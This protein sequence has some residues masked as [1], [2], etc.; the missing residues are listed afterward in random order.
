MPQ[1]FTQTLIPLTFMLLSLSC[2]KHED[3]L[4]WAKQDKSVLI[5]DNPELNVISVADD[6][7]FTLVHIK[8]SHFSQIYAEKLLEELQKSTNLQQ[9]RVKQIDYHQLITNINSQQ[10]SIIDFVLKNKDLI[11][12]IYVEGLAYPG[13]YEVTSYDEKITLAKNLCQEIFTLKQ[14]KLSSPS[15]PYFTGASN[16]LYHQHQIPVLGSE[17]QGLLRLTHRAYRNEWNPKINPREMIKAC[18]DERE[19][20][21]L[22]NMAK[23]IEENNRY[24]KSLKFLIC[25]EAHDFSDNVATWNKDNP[26]QQYN[27]IEYIP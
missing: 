4:S 26:Q 7:L 12:L 3:K 9:V 18:H 14:A 22:K 8:Q 13:T 21:I 23:D 5:R 27:L 24:D 6:R 17:H 1:R 11:D 25:G 10:I 19:T 2:L 16:F 20:Q 15:P